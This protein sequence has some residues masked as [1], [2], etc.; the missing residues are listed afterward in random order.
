MPPKA[1]Q[2]AAVVDRR[3]ISPG[4][5]PGLRER[6]LNRDLTAHDLRN[7]VGVILG[8]CDLLSQDLADGEPEHLGSEV[9][10]IRTA[11][12]RVA[13]LLSE[14]PSPRQRPATLSLREFAIAEL[15]F[16]RRL[17][18]PSAR[19][20]LE[21]VPEGPGHV[22]VPATG[23][24]R[25]VGNLVANAAHAL[26]PEGHIAL[27]VFQCDVDAQPVGQGGFVAFEVVDDGCGMTEEVLRRATEPRFTTRGDHG[28]SGLGLAGAAAF[29][30]ENGG[31]FELESRPGQGTIAR[32]VLPASDSASG[33]LAAVDP[34][35]RPRLRLA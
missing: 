11:A 6:Q 32:L 17:A 29:A 24:Q 20:E 25:A 27:R 28:G 3:G 4:L 1:T 16:L 2:S 14:A 35:E 10:A 30:D 23:L 26:G 12:E 7:L 8:G 22:D 21:E 19:V 18:G 34:A 13:D 5:R 33:A 15:P 9:D 31:R